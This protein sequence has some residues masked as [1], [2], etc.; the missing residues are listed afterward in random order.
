MSGTDAGRPAAPGAVLFDFGGVLFDCTMVA[1]GYDA[2]AAHVADLL[3]RATMRTVTADEVAPGIRTA[4]RIFRGWKDGQSEVDCPR[5]VTSVQW[6]EWASRSWP[7]QW[8]A[9]VAV[10][11]VDLCRRLDSWSQ[12]RLPKPGMHQV[13]EWLSGAGIPTAVVSN[14]LAGVENRRLLDDHG[15][16]ALLGPQLYSD[17]QGLRKPNPQLVWRACEA[18]GTPVEHTWFVG[19]APDRDVRV[20]RRA[21]V[22]RMVLIPSGPL[23]DDLGDDAPDAITWTPADLLTELRSAHCRGVRVPR[24]SGVGG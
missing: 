18:L 9:V 20:A 16:A 3:S 23:P 17:E 13:L 7:A 24:R 6:W 21:G 15:M 5:E 1:A 2:L 11:A 10:H 12:T 4:E 8:R 19:D 14:T 22:G